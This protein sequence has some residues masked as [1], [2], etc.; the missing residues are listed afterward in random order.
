MDESKLR[1]SDEEA[2]AEK[3]QAEA[4]AAAKGK[5]TDKEEKKKGE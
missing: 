4:V 2:L 5:P 3:E 1:P